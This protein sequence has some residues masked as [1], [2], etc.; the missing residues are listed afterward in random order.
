MKQWVK[1]DFAELGAQYTEGGTNG[2]EY[3]GVIYDT[4]LG[5]LYGSSGQTPPP[6]N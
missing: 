4:V 5:K 3:D 6:H 1:P 2:G